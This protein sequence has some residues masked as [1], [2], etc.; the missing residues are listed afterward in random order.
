MT[1]PESPRACII[2]LSTFPSPPEKLG[3]FVA[4]SLS[5]KSL[6]VTFLAK[7]V[8]Q[9]LCFCTQGSC[10]LKRILSYISFES[11]SHFLHSCHQHRP[12][13]NNQLLFTLQNKTISSSMKLCP[14]FQKLNLWQLSTP[15]RDLQKCSMF[16]QFITSDCNRQNAG[17]LKFYK[18]FSTNFICWWGFFI[19]YFFNFYFLFSS[20]TLKKLFLG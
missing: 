5:V 8:S 16:F 13:F 12:C 20:L 1:H 9:H 14:E 18:D 17:C 4:C 3:L 11:L 6:L 7:E 19:I 15:C 2:A 10:P